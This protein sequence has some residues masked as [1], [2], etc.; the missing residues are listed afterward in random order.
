MSIA[1][2]TFYSWLRQGLSKHIEP[3]K[4]GAYRGF[5]TTELSLSSGDVVTKEIELIGPADIKA[6]DH[7]NIVK[8]HPAPN[9]GDFEANYLPFIEF[10]QDSF[11]WDYSPEQANGERL[12]PWLFLLVL[13]KG[14]YDLTENATELDH[15]LVHDISSLP[16]AGQVW[17]WAHVHVNSN[18]STI[19]ALQDQLTTNPD[20]ATSRLLSPRRLSPN[21]AYEAFVIPAYEIGRQAG[22]GKTIDPNAAGFN[23][24]APSWGGGQVLKF[25]VYYRWSFQTGLKGDFESLVRAL[26]PRN[27]LDESIGFR[28]MDITGAAFPPAVNPPVADEMPLGGALKPVGSGVPVFSESDWQVEVSN[29]LNQRDKQTGGNTDPMVVPPTYG[30]WHVLVEQLNKGNQTGPIDDGDSVWLHKLN[31]DPANR[32][33]AGV[34]TAVIQ[35]NQEHYLSIAWDQIGSVL[36][37][38]ELLK[39]SQLGIEIAVKW[40]DKHIT[41]Q[42]D[43]ELV[44]M[45]QPLWDSVLCTSQPIPNIALNFANSGTPAAAFSPVFRR[46]KNSRIVRNLEKKRDR[47]PAYSSFAAGF[48]EGLQAVKPKT[49]ASGKDDVRYIDDPNGVVRPLFPCNFPGFP[50]ENGILEFPKIYPEF[51]EGDMPNELEVE[52]DKE[53][54]MEAWVAF[55]RAYECPKEETLP[56]P[57]NLGAIVPCIKA[58]LHPAETIKG[59][60]LTKIGTAAD[61]DAITPIMAAPDYPEPMYKKLL[62]QSEDFILPNLNKLPN[63]TITLMETNQD[64][65]EAFMVGLNVEMA[66]ELLWNE[67]PTDQ[68]GSYFRQFWDVSKYVDW[69]N[70]DAQELAER[71]KDIDFIHRWV[72]WTD[73]G[74]HRMSNRLPSEPPKGEPLVLTIRGDLLNRYPEAIIFAVE[75]KNNGS[76]DASNSANVK[77]PIF[78]ATVPPDI[79]FLGFELT[80]EEV[81]RSPTNP[82]WFFAIKE[83]AAGPRFGMDIAITDTAI[84]NWNDLHWGHMNDPN[85]IDLTNTTFADTILTGTWGD[86][87]ANMASILYQVPVLVAIHGDQ[88]LP[89]D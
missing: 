62:E 40:W 3:P 35:E 69:N 55:Q 81:R 7:R 6:I 56:P 13:A 71:L 46:L 4:S 86:D 9:T 38:N 70:T 76:F 26:V 57:I 66:T 80:E 52:V 88:L 19:S 11:L 45:V 67:Y 2:Y 53:A 27:E 28:P 41:S 5:V 30:H 72:K 15:L 83:P 54:F 12:K 64:F 22:I 33:A 17:A 49:I 59:R 39:Q 85:N 31:L 36:E 82:G 23:A 65:I 63:N 50:S 29:L 42:E 32:A 18:V 21:T 10:Y 87:A 1:K 73:L 61:L 84:D 68:R 51:F 24:L 16:P 60:T 58:G 37:A 75:A 47:K 43:G 20:F 14:E 8:L 79:T 34:G 25:P 44:S 74:D 89:Q 48:E 77:Y 78:S